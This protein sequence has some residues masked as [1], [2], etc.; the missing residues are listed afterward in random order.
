MKKNQTTV[1]IV[2]TVIYKQV[3]ISTQI[4]ARNPV[5]ALDFPFWANRL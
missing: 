2:F 3:I 1:R 5:N 4:P